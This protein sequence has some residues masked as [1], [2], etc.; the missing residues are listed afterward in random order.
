MSYDDPFW[1]AVGLIEKNRQSF[2]YYCI[3][4]E[5]DGCTRR[6]DLQLVGRLEKY[7]DIS[8]S[9][10]TPIKKKYGMCGG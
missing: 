4:G 9:H 2:L 3:R 10:P 1:Q 8:A 6:F 5:E 7:S